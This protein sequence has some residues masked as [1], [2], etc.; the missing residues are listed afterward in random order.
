VQRRAKTDR[1]D[2]G[3][4]Q[5]CLMGWLRGEKKHLGPALPKCFSAEQI[6][7]QSAMAGAA[8]VS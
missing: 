8:K 5:G 4:L 3:P 1:L 6:I 2:I 7:M